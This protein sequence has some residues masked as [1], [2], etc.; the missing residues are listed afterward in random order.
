MR[1]TRDFEERERPSHISVYRDATFLSQCSEQEARDWLKNRPVGYGTVYGTPETPRESHVFE[2]ILYRRN[3]PLV[4]LALAEYGRSRSVLERVFKRASLSTRVVACANASLFSGDTLREGIFQNTR[5]L[6]WHIVEHGSLAELRAVCENPDLGSGWYG[7]IVGR[8]EGNNTDVR[9]GQLSDGPDTEELQHVL[10]ARA[11]P[12]HVLSSDRF[13]WIL[14]FLSKNP[15]ISTPREESRQRYYYDPVSDYEYNELFTKGWKLAEIVP[16]EREWA[17]VLS[18]FYRGLHRPRDLFFDDVETVLARWRPADEGDASLRDEEASHFLSVREEIAAKFIEPSVEMLENNDPAIRQAFYRTFDPDSHEF[19]ELDWTEWLSRDEYCHI[20][21]ELN[22]KIWRSSVGRQNLRDLLWHKP[23]DLTDV[24]FFDKREQVLRKT[25]P[26]WFENEQEE[27]G[28]K[29]PEPD[30]I[31][32]LERA[33]WDLTAT[34]SKRRST[35]AVWFLLAALI[36][37][38]IG[39]AICHETGFQLPLTRRGMESSGIE[40]PL[41]DTVFTLFLWY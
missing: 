28:D 15:R 39:V 23:N 7:S 38:F 29:E 25:N 6:L 14:F 10:G 20:W 33:V 21:L 24:G 34:F 36:G 9:A 5:P 12:G 22:N 17:F 30:R 37:F 18:E 13:K 1:F 3:L 4:D 26:E 16:V 35:S 31:G 11:N 32:D 19:R 27:S 41:H 2:Y 40:Y 8:W